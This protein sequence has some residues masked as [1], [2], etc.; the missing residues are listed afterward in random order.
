MRM[1]CVTGLLY[2]LSAAA[3]A[4]DDPLVTAPTVDLVI[5][6]AQRSNP[7]LAEARA[8]TRAAEAR[9]QAEGRRPDLELKYEQWAV[10]LARPYALDEANMLM[11][12]VRQVFPAAGSLSARQRAAT[13]DAHVMAASLGIRELDIEQDIRKAFAAYV[14]ADGDWQAHLDHSDLSSRIID[15][16]RTQY[17]AGRLSQEEVLRATAEH[18]RLHADVTLAHQERRSA[19]AMLNALMGRP[20]DAP[21]GPPASPALPDLA[22][23]LDVLR[24]GIEQHRPEIAAG[25]S[26]ISRAEASRDAAEAER[27]WPMF[28]VGLDYMNM[29]TMPE[30]HGY[31]AMVSMSL[32][33]LNSGHE[34]EMRSAEAEIAAERSAL[35]A[36]RLAA[37][38][39]LTDAFARAETARSALDA[40]DREVLPRTQEAFEASRIAFA[41]GRASALGVVD[42]ERALLQ[43]RI[44]RLR[45]VERLQNAIA[46]LER[47]A[48]AS[49]N[50]VK[51]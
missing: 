20:A 31:G 46:D 11:I 24:A 29:P 19:A 15:L 13:G 51:P 1:L 18:A 8:R 10:P 22:I 14:R 35:E 36:T 37:Q 39:Q 45:A 4:A 2:A 32:P 5:Q 41:G 21:L 26:A 34:A 49:V 43:V 48:G 30:P 16:A 28:M 40:L 47:A 33:W 27:K 3:L 9:A 44:D 23:H 38:Y 12:G 17:A 7:S 50:E 42:S 25:A 6:T